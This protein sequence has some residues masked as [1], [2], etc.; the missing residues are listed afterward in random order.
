MY[1]DFLKTIS[2]LPQFL[3]IF[4][5]CNHDIVSEKRRK[6]HQT[7]GG[8]FAPSTHISVD[9]KITCRLFFNAQQHIQKQTNWRVTPRIPSL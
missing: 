1:M 2:P 5:F 4:S 6:N 8:D 3:L 9:K 7:S